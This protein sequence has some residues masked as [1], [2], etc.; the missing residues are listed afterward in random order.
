LLYAAP[1]CAF[2]VYSAAVYAAYG[3][4]PSTPVA[5]KQVFLPSLLIDFGQIVRNF[6]RELI[7]D[8]GP[9]GIL[10]IAALGYLI[11]QCRHWSIANRTSRREP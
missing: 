9:E 2:A 7:T 5:F 4:F 3:H 11:G 6:P 1:L 10:L 8:L